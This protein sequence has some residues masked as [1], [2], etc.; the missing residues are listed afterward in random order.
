MGVLP[1]TERKKR[2]TKGE[3]ILYGCLDTHIVRWVF[4]M[5]FRIIQQ[6]GEQSIYFEIFFLFHRSI[7]AHQF[8]PELE[9][10]T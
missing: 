10:E 4:E 1:H 9:G 7:T 3:K 8:L 2:G 6:K 5:M